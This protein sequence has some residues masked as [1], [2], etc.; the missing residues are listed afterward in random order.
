MTSSADRLFL[1]G[2]A[3]PEPH[4]DWELR[5]SSVHHGDG[6]TVYVRGELDLASAPARER[7]LDER[8]AMPHQSVNLDQAELA[9]MDSTGLHTLDRLRRDAAERRVRF[10]LAAVPAI[11]ER[12][13]HVTAMEKVFEIETRAPVLGTGA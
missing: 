1:R 11:V 13:L 4:D 5:L 10:T 3:P 9:F 6:V 2:A 12:L 8:L 7:R